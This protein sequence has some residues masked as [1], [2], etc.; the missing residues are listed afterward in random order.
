MA[1]TTVTIMAKKLDKTRNQLIGVFSSLEL[2]PR[3]TSEARDTIRDEMDTAR[4]LFVQLASG[5]Y[6]DASLVTRINRMIEPIEQAIKAARL[7]Q[8]ITNRV[9]F[10][11]IVPP[12]VIK[13]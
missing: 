8:T 11:L 10:D 2:G 7:G 6:A 13:A 1:D 9:L 12:K 5:D 4:V 3:F